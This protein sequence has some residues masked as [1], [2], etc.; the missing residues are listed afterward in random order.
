[1]EDAQ[2]VD[3]LHIA[4]PEIE[5]NGVLLREEVE[6]IEGLRLCFGDGWDVR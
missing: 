5:A 4:L 6:R 2:V 1:M 3:I